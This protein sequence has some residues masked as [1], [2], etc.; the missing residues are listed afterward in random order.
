MRTVLY[1]A[2]F[3]AVQ[4]TPVIQEDFQRLLAAQKPYKLAM[5]ACMRKLLTILNALVRD[6]VQWGEKT[7]PNVPAQT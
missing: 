1:M 7:R 2:A 4:R 6:N 3:N 5:T